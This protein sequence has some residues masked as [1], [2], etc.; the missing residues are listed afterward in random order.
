MYLFKSVTSQQGQC[1]GR[2]QI[3]PSTAIGL[4]GLSA[5]MTNCGL[6]LNLADDYPLAAA[7][8]P[9]VHLLNLTSLISSLILKNIFV[10]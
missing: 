3:A 8:H 7:I 10:K 2:C 6:L 4:L 5:K 1:G 9:L